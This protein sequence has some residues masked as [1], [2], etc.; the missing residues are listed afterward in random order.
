MR[1]KA[2]LN[3]ETLISMVAKGLS[4][5]ADALPRVEL[6]TVLY[7][8]ERMQH[9]IS[10]LYAYIIRFFIRAHDWYQESTLHHVLHAITRP[11]ELRYKDLLDK[12]TER[13]HAV[14]QLALSASQ[15]EQ[16]T[17]HKK[18]DVVVA[19]LEQS[20]AQ[21]HELKRLMI[22]KWSCGIYK[23]LLSKEHSIPRRQLHL[24]S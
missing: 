2:C 10:E 9:V 8:S 6:A 20:E 22:C 18:L 24:V 15:E 12:I 11:A 7:P 17:M 19:K 14:D 3:H 21:V 13:S 4:Q 5:I 16:R 1:R 23:D